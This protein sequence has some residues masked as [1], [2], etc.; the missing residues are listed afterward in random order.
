MVEQLKLCKRERK[1]IEKMNL[2]MYYKYNILLS[3]SF[4]VIKIAFWISVH[5][6]NPINLCINYFLTDLLF[7]RYN[8]LPFW[9]NSFD[10]AIICHAKH[11]GP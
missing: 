9:T 4:N 2:D 3:L 10:F 1:E 7:L 5:G 11:R 8:T 6:P